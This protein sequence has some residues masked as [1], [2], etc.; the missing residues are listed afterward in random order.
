MALGG[1]HSGEVMIVFKFVTAVE[2]TSPM[3]A[4]RRRTAE[5]C[6]V[7]GTLTT[8]SIL[9]ESFHILTKLTVWLSPLLSNSVSHQATVMHLN[10]TRTALYLSLS[11]SPPHISCLAFITG[12]G[13]CLFPTWNIFI[14]AATI[15]SYIAEYIL[16]IKKLL[17][18]SKLDIP[19]NCAVRVEGLFVSVIPK[20][21]LQFCF[22]SWEDVG[23]VFCLE[24]HGSTLN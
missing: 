15:Q 18:G 3:V 17:I 20:M 12:V 1:D 7:S 11:L 22:E 23:L 21:V 2:M 24:F 13:F 8:C 9:S 5:L 6:S 16:V 4:G 10:Y 14:L 19:I